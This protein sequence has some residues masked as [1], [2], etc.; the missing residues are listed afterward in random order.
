MD[1]QVRLS[2]GREGSSTL[3]WST[4]RCHQA[5][6]S[7]KHA[8]VRTAKST[9]NRSEPPGVHGARSG[10]KKKRTMEQEQLPSLPNSSVEVTSIETTIPCSTLLLLPAIYLNHPRAAYVHWAKN[11]KKYLVRQL[12]EGGGSK[13]MKCQTRTLC[14]ETGISHAM[15]EDDNPSIPHFPNPYSSPTPLQHTKRCASHTTTRQTLH[16]QISQQ[17]P[18]QHR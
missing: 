17:H 18:W 8:I 12:G 14:P 1:S 7:M 11:Y 6:S 2:I 15:P 9:I 10:R 13:V 5:A 4:R 3:L 16:P